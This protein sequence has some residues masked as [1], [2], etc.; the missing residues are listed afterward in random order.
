MT[1]AAARINSMVYPDTSGLQFQDIFDIDEIQRI[2]D[3]F[4]EAL[5]VAS[6]VTDTAG[7]PITRPSHFTRFCLLVRSH[8]KGLA[9][10]SHSDAVIGAGKQDGPIVCTCMSG[11]LFDGGTGISVGE[12]PIANWLVG[13]VIDHEP[14]EAWLR[15]FADEIGVDAAELLAAAAEVPRMSRQRFEKICHALHLIGKQLSALA[16]KT[17]QQ[18]RYIDET[19]AAY[20]ALRESEERYRALLQQSSEAIVLID[21]STRK[22]IEVN[23]RFREMLGYSPQEMETKTA[24]DIVAD[25]KESVDR[26]YDEVLPLRP[27]LPVELRPFRHR[28]GRVIEVERSGVLVHL[29]GKSVYMVTARDVSE[30]ILA[31]EKLNFLSFHDTLTG[32][33]NRAYFEDAL[34]KYDRRREIGVGLIIFDLDGLK[35]VN[36]SFGHEQGDALLIRAGEMIE[37][38]FG[39]DCVAARIG[40]DEFAVLL[41]G[42][43]PES[44]QA[45]ALRA[46]A[47]SEAQSQGK[48]RIPLSLSIGYAISTRKEMSMRD[49][50]READNNMYREKLHRSQSTRSAIVQT[51]MSLLEARDYITEGHA[52][53]L[54][55]MVIRLARAVGLPENRMTDLR[56]L[57]QFH[58]IGKVGIPDRILLKPGTL[59]T[60]EMVEM[61]RHSEIGHRIAQSSP[62]LLP[63]ADWVLKHQEWWDG[64]GYPLGIAGEAIPI[65]CRILA[66]ADAYDAMTSD[67]PYRQAM[68]RQ[69]AFD[70]L[71]RCAGTQFDPALV[72]IFI[73]IFA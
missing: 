70:E 44:L 37:S 69:A 62:D 33:F 49:L 39:G 72:D 38:S 60:A 68:P 64:S 42:M 11:G 16:L 9:A 22:I 65:E 2:Q 27:E 55:D 32:L 40:G 36:D 35:L 10:C 48:S 23:R 34:A 43:T 24:Y 15:Q 5:G 1:D 30:R 51:V 12:R 7:R 8:P 53:R 41:R 63:V 61:K 3:A 26:Y 19:A 73:T 17:W 57:A 66:I 25:S 20:E 18:G 45:A 31:E 58:D 52:D 50:F 29:A 28:N 67:R 71:R 59:T 14:D 6:L 4:A 46:K 21:P 54:Q 13:Q 56:L 47:K